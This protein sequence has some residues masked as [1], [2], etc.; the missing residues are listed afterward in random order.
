MD[1][2]AGR[3]RRRRR[4]PSRSSSSRTRGGSGTRRRGGSARVASMSAGRIPAWTW[5]SPSQT[6]MRRPS[7]LLD[8][9]AEQHVGAEQDLGVGAVGV[10]DVAHDVD[11]VG[12]GA[13][14][15]GERLDL[16]GGVDVHHDHAP[17]VALPARRRA[18]R[19]RS[20]PTAS[21]RRR[22]RGSGRSSTGERIEAVSAMKCTPQKT[23]VSPSAARRPAREAERVADEVGDVLD[24]GQLVVV[25]ED[26][27]VAL[28]G[29]R[30]HL[31]AGAPRSPAGRAPPRVPG[32]V[33]SAGSWQSRQRAARGRGPGPSASAHPSRSSLRR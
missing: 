10:V 32:M 12:G 20:S 29:E 33:P 18:A 8:V 11:R 17:R 1:A 5:H 9:G 7:S 6:C 26:H 3:R 15:V 27:R 25:G 23:I 31:A 19:R 30:P 2:L 28:G 14:V 13:A 16:G 4:T 22:G 21:S 24:L